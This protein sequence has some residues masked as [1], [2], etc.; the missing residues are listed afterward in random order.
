MDWLRECSVAGGIPGGKTYPF[1]ARGIERD[2][3]A[4]GGERRQLCGGYDFA[5]RSLAVAPDQFDEFGRP[6]PIHVDGEGALVA[7]PLNG[8]VMQENFARGHEEV[9][10]TQG[11]EHRRPAVGELREAVEL[12]V[13]DVQLGVGLVF[14]RFGVSVAFGA[15]LFAAQPV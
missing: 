10:G 5:A 15:Q 9:A 6:G 12:D 11:I 14:W 1:L 4:M 2:A 13:V 7:R 8:V 3:V